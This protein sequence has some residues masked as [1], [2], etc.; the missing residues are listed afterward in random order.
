MHYDSKHNRWKL[1]TNTKFC[2]WSCAKAYMLDRPNY[3]LASLLPLLRKQ[4]TGHSI[5]DGIKAAPPKTALKMFGGHMSIDEF[6]A[7]KDNNSGACY[8]ELPS[9][10]I[11]DAPVLTLVPSVTP[12]S[13]GLSLKPLNFDNLTPTIRNE[14]LRLRRPKTAKGKLNSAANNVML[15]KIFGIATSSS[16]NNNNNN[17]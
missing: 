10:V 6:R 3:Q 12:R 15:E 14:T 9:N 2:S 5:A 17:N 13:Q 4:T 8:K 11:L 1:A 7:D 16:T